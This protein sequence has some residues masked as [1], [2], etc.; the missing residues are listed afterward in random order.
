MASCAMLAL[1]INIDVPDL[2]QGISFYTTAFDLQVARRLGPDFAELTG[3][4]APLYLLQTRAG[5]PPFPNAL[6]PRTYDRH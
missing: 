3:A 4:Q 6:A 5:T 2:D 1:L